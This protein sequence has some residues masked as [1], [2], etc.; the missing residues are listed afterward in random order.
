MDRWG[1]R[2]FLKCSVGLTDVAL[3]SL[4]QIVELVPESRVN[5]EELLESQPLIDGVRVSLHHILDELSREPE[6]DSTIDD[7]SYE[8]FKCCVSLREHCWIQ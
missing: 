3:S 2:S 7:M 1:C 6:N 5:P 8:C 4:D